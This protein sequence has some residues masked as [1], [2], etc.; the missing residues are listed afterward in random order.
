MEQL[1]DKKMQIASDLAQAHLV[2]AKIVS[3]KALL[4]ALLAGGILLSSVINLFVGSS[5]MTVEETAAALLRQGTV[6]ENLIVWDIRMPVVLSAVAIGAALGIAGCEMQ[7]ILRNP[8]AS[9]YTLGLSSAASFGAALA[10]IMRIGLITVVGKYMVAA[11]SLLF[12]LLASV[13][14]ITFAKKFNSDRGVIILFGI[15]L[16]F[17]FSSLTTIMQYIADENDLQELVF[18]SFGSLT[19]VTW[20]KLAV[21][22]VVTIVCFANFM[23]KS[24]MLTAMSLSDVNAKS[25]G[26]DV[27]KVRRNT[28]FIVALL[29]SATVSFA[30]PI[31]FIGLVAPH[32][33]RMLS[34]EDQRYFLPTAALIG[35]FFLSAASIFSKAL[36]P[37]TILPI[38]LVTSVI[39]IPFF[40]SL[41][42]RRK[43]SYM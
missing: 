25:L 3:K 16:N 6:N 26:I 21:I 14:I 30:G 32:I 23:K 33:A 10:I 27:G 8:M 37:G 1:E 20:E 19:K 12:T 34:G 2:Y 43:R 40:I 13:T 41:I 9:A 17:L 39:G 24:W 22:G 28:I 42:V 38:G 29:T 31:G 18:W 35:A 11:N 5:G 36:I 7:T 15:A 4:I